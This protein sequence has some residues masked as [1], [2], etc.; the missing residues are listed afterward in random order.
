MAKM[1]PVD[2]KMAALSDGWRVLRD[3][4]TQLSVSLLEDDRGISQ[5][6]YRQLQCLFEE[7]GAMPYL[8]PVDDEDGRVR[9]AREAMF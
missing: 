5:R 6:S 8:P 1:V 9:M 2:R 3:R 4:I 7:M